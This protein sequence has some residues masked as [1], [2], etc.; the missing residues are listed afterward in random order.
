MADR[1]E[2]KH[3]NHSLKDNAK[4]KN[5]WQSTKL[6]AGWKSGSLDWASEN[7]YDRYIE[8]YALEVLFKIL[9]EFYAT[10]QKEDGEDFYKR[11][12]LCAVFI[13][14]MLLINKKSDDFSCTIWNK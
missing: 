2:S 6:I 8:E 14:C 1:G 10:V 5:T 7:C 3:F 11:G 12:S 13:S 4:N 9:K